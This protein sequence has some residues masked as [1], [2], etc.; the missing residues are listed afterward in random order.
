MSDAGGQTMV[1]VVG[2]ERHQIKGRK[3]F[4]TRISP[5]GVAAVACGQT[6]GFGQ[7]NTDLAFKEAES[8]SANLL[9]RID[10]QV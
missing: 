5:G 2:L 1:H 4:F 3:V 10:N 8:A 6:A 9:L 7:K